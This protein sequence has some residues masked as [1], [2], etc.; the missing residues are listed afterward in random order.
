MENGKCHQLGEGELVLPLCRPILHEVSLGRQKSP[1]LPAV[2]QPLVVDN[3]ASSGQAAQELDRTT[4][5]G[6]EGTGNGEMGNEGM[7]NGEMGNEGTEKW[8]MREWGRRERGME[9]G[10]MREWG[11]EKWE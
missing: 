9:K 11:M 1:L 8:G 2:I 3:V 4:D 5:L 6:N 10:G 7:G